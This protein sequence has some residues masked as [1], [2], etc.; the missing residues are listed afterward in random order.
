MPATKQYDG[1]VI[2]D[3]VRLSPSQVAA[4]TTASVAPVTVLR[5]LSILTGSG[6]RYGQNGTP[7]YGIFFNGE[8]WVWL[9][10]NM[11]PISEFGSWKVKNLNR[12]K[13]TFS[14]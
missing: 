13:F 8:H 14:R 12:S 6:K 7:R 10:K 3:G 11:K 9:D 5:P 4:V 2:V 1:S